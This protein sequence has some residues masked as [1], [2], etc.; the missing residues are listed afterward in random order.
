VP[1]CIYNDEMDVVCCTRG[2]QQLL[3]KLCSE[4]AEGRDLPRPVWRDNI[5][6]DV[7]E[8]GWEDL[9]LIRVAYDMVQERNIVNVR[10][11]SNVM[12]SMSM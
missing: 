11:S 10:V 4:Y 2:R 8:I 7:T 12:N 6:M 5:E 3:E 9:E 1:P